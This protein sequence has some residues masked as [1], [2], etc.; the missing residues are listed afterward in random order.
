[1]PYANRRQAW[2]GIQPIAPF[3]REGCLQQTAQCWESFEFAEAFPGSR[4]IYN[5]AALAFFPRGRLLPGGEARAQMLH[6]SFW[7]HTKVAGVPNIFGQSWVAVPQGAE[8][9]AVAWF[10]PPAWALQ[11]T[12]PFPEDLF[13]VQWGLQL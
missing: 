8:Y 13:R 9:F 6:L 12:G 1:M 5:I 11:N 7:S 4:G 10:A 2:L 3:A